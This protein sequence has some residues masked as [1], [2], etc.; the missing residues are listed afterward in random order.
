MNGYDGRRKEW[1]N[2]KELWL[3]RSEKKR[4]INFY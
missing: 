4:G 2:E 1:E 3:V